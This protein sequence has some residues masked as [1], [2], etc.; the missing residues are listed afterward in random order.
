MR[1]ESPFQADD[2]QDLDDRLLSRASAVVPM[3]QIAAGRK[4]PT[5]IGLRHDVDN[6]LAPAVA[7]A[8]WEHERSYRS[9]YFIL[10]S[11]DYWAEK[12]TLQAALE[13]IAGCDHEIAYHLNAI[14][15]AI[16]TGRDPV[17]IVEETLAE[18]RGYGYD[19]TGVVAHGD[20]ACYT[21][22]FVN[23]ELFTES[24]RPTYGPPSRMVGGVLLEPVSRS[25]FGF[26]YDANWLTRAAYLSDS[27]GRW[28][29][30]FDTVADGFP[31]TGQLHCLVHA[32]WWQ[33]A[34]VPEQ[35]AV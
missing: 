6:V 25:R 35:V 13:V 32:D 1:S 2:L 10:P 14:T 29:Q 5:V 27:G 30:P 18:L 17:E 4:D 9:T 12:E 24:P 15:T 3:W 20:A 31:Y 26:E 28:S 19:V 7:M 21:H 22:G 16:E 11:A 33:Q 34:F 8:E 23:D